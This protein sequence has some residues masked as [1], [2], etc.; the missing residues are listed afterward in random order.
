MGKEEMDNQTSE[1]KLNKPSKPKSDK[2]LENALKNKLG[3]RS[4]D[5]LVTT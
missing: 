3:Q 5:P 4:N 2:T 1:E